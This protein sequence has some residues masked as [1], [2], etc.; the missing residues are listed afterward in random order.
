[1][2]KSAKY[3]ERKIFL[4]CLNSWFSNFIIEEFRTDYLPDAR[5]KNTFMGT[6]DCSGA[7]LPRLFEP[8]ETTVEI[9]YNYNQEIF[10]ND[11]FIYNLDDANLAEVEFVI[12]G[13]RNIK[14]SSEKV[15][16]IVSNI[17]TWA[18]TPNKTFTEEEMKAED[19]DEE[20]VIEVKEEEIKP[21][22]E[23]EKKEENTAEMKEEE[24]DR[25]SE[26]TKDLKDSRRDKK[27]ESKKDVKKK[28]KETFNSK[29]EK[30]SEKK[31]ETNT[32]KAEEDV[33]TNSEGR[34]NVTGNDT[35][36]NNQTTENKEEKKAEGVKPEEPKPRYFYYKDSEYMKRIPNNRYFKYKI[37][38]SLALSNTNPMLKV[39][40]ICPGFVY[41]C[42]EN[43][44]FDYFRLCW[45]GTCPFIPIIGEGGNHLPT[46]HILDLVHVIKR[47]LE[48]KP[49]ENYIVACDKTK[50]KRMKN[51][52]ESIAKAMGN[53]E[54]KCLRDFNIDEV[55]IPLYTELSIDVKIKPSKIMEDEERMKG[56]DKEDYEKRKFQ[57][58][59]EYG[60][61][62][63][64]ALLRE[65]FNL[66]RG[67]K[68]IKII[69]LGPPC[70]G[71]SLI[72]SK[73]SKK[74]KISHLQTP[75]VVSWAQSLSNAFGELTRQ[76]WRE[77]EE[78]VA[79]ALDEYEHRK[80]KRKND[81]PL[82]VS[83]IK[84][85]DTEFTAR[86]FKEK[87][88]G[89]ECSGKGYVMDN[90]PKTYEDCVNLYKSSDGDAI[91]QNLLPDSVVVINDYLEDSLKKKLE[92]D[93]DYQ[94]KQTEILSRFNRRLMK[95]KADNEITEQNTKSVLTFFEENNIKIHTVS[96]VRYMNFKEEEEAK[97]EE[98]LERNGPIDNYEKLH[99]TEE[100]I[101]F[102]NEKDIYLNDD[103]KMLMNN[104]ELEGDFLGV[105]G[106]FNDVIKEDDENSKENS[107]K[108]VSQIKE[109]KVEDDLTENNSLEKTIKSKEIE[110]SKENKN[111][112]IEKSENKTLND[113]LTKQE[114][115]EKLIQD[116]LNEM[117]VRE[118]N[119]LEKK[120]EVL[121]RY[122]S[123]NVIPIL[124][125]GILNV[126]QNMPEDPVEGLANYLLDHEFNEGI[127]GE[128]GRGE[129][130]K[131]MNDSE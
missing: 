89:G 28:R 71:K 18:D 117:K 62:E 23:P 79:K 88:M 20:E 123:E 109:R 126:C 128:E 70:G 68:P 53:G 130:E 50:D 47:V 114:L 64:L 21:P 100:I 26:A 85:F 97:I 60:I 13:L 75:A 102:K 78:N 84:K 55:D 31:E 113:I 17:M 127:K 81:Q 69:V 107:L 49:V 111:Q 1:M 66:Y 57:W 8:K 32:N 38:E 29:A 101:P 65:E 95:Y 37:L 121:R 90:Y 56:E 52:I 16:I 119:L 44:F 96:E 77:V 35:R 19:F 104:D 33:K 43:F 54:V 98:Y 112:I 39:Y 22:V 129:L 27:K 63:N 46:I 4:N 116:K 94:E 74:L 9:G 58:H 86:I 45:F 83:Q 76:K 72:A 2:S 41:G 91:D 11:V 61:P 59:C 73:L 3:R 118:K 103:E 93:P 67:I 7:P 87:L 15:L 108:D 6:V 124:A 110:E 125:K 10:S 14:Y 12:R 51:V 105:K 24:K 30:E 36:L 82:D 115:Q 25:A 131:I 92:N 80:N 40:I 5:V 34:E 48:R 99:D 42:G 120:S 122:L 106:K